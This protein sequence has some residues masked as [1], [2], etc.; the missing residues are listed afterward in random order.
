MAGAI[1]W[2]H[3]GIDATGT[4]APPSI[5][6]PKAPTLPMALSCCIVREMAV[7]AIPNALSES[8]STTMIRPMAT[9]DPLTRKSNSGPPSTNSSAS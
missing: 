6:I 1:A 2:A 5:A 9:I 8:A 7:T 3:P 4:Q